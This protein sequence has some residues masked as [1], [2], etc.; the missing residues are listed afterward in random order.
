M[1]KLKIRCSVC[2]KSFKTPSAKKTICPSCDAEAKRAKHQHV[3]VPEQ[4]PAAPTA[5][6][7]VRAV[8][9]AGQENRGEFAAYKAPAPPAPETTAVTTEKQAAAK[10]AARLG[11][12]PHPDRAARPA[13]A[14]RP[15]REPKVREVQKPFEP[16]PEQVE[17]IRA[18][19][20]ELANPEYDGIRHTIANELG[21]P[22]R[23]VKQKVKELREEKAIA[24][25]WESGQ[26]LPTPDQ[27]ELVRALYAPQL[28]EPAIGIHKQIAKELKLANTSVYLAIGHIRHE[29]DL[30]R[31]NDRPEIATQ[32]DGGN[33]QATEQAMVAVAML[34]QNGTAGQAH[35]GE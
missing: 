8:L 18:R 3:P 24:S 22:L 21:I 35:A 32:E 16:T 30:P 23:V 6:V 15:P 19:Y 27:I 20:L 5:A 14:P 34:E 1:N 29:L 33:E 4:R 12:Q 17:A 25:W 28:P 7:D 10:P 31:Y 13:P 9:R 2:G 11:R 26:M